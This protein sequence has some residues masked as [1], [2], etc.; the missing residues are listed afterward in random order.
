MFENDLI[1]SH[2]DNNHP[3]LAK[4]ARIDALLDLRGFER[5]DT[6]EDLK[7]IHAAHA[8]ADEF[9]DLLHIELPVS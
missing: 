9:H 8:T 3:F 6:A 7:H 1:L 4:K 5:L 2:V